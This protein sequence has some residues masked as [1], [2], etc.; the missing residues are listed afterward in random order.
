L[1]LAVVFVLTSDIYNSVVPPNESL[2]GLNPFFLAVFG[3]PACCPTL[4]AVCYH[5]ASKDLLPGGWPTF[6]GGI[7]TR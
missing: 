3:L 1:P 4:K 7:R 5:A 6:R 2:T